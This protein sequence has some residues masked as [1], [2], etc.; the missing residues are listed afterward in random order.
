MLG[1][2]FNTLLAPQLFRSFAEYPLVL[3]AACLLRPA[4][5]AGGDARRRAL[6]A[7]LPVALLAAL[8]AAGLALGGGGAARWTLFGLGGAA[9]LIVAGRPVR[10]GLALAALIVAGRLSHAP[11]GEVLASERNFFGPAEVM[12]AAGSRI[13]YHGKTIHGAQVT[14]AR[15]RATPL[16]YYTAAGPLGDVFRALAPRLEGARI[17][18][19]GL[20]SGALAAYGRPGQQMVFH[21]INPAVARIANDPRLF[22][23]LSDSKAD[24]AV[25]I[26]DGRLGLAQEAQDRY[27]LIVV[28]AFNSDAVPVHLLT[29]EAIGLYLAR[30]APGGVLLF[31]AT[32]DYLDLEGV[33]GRA[34]ADAGL[35]AL[36][37]C[38]EEPVSTTE[39]IPFKLPSDWVALARTDADLAGLSGTPGW[40]VPR[41]RPAQRP[42]TDDR[43]SLLGAFRGL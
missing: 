25:R 39:D 15:H 32:N 26:G 10:F 28:D 14:T 17:A 24:V 20:G 22:T 3:V 23:Y 6:D 37:R 38:D 21:E 29:R 13:L 36:V 18:V 11:L 12:G 4:P 33:L 7:A 41:Y 16:A 2:V 5:A 8:A 34:A 42:W 27:A 35:S 43:A 19:V 40:R 30:L 9:C 1:G 31:N